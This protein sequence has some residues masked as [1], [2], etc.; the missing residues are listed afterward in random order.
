MIAERV[1]AENAF[2]GRLLQSMAQRKKKTI[3]QEGRLEEPLEAVRRMVAA[4]TKTP[5]VISTADIRAEIE[6]LK[7]ERT[8]IAGLI[9]NIERLAVLRYED[10][11]ATSKRGPK[12][13]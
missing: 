1:K 9:R 2:S 5:G 12:V 3:T 10:V 13:K 7:R 11:G 4:S 6:R 8:M